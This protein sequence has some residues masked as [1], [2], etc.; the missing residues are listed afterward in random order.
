MSVPRSSV[1]L[2]L[3]YVFCAVLVLLLTGCGS[4]GLFGTGDSAA[5]KGASGASGVPGPPGAVAPSPAASPV[6]SPAGP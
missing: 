2:R 5:L 4:G 6:P 1:P 3:P